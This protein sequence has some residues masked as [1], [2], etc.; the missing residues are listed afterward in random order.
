MDMTDDAVNGFD[1]L[2]DECFRETV[3]TELIVPHRFV[4]IH[5]SA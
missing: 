1:V 4:L 5:V 2:T 3:L